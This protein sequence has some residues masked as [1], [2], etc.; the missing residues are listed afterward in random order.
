MPTMVKRIQTSCGSGPYN[1][2]MK[3]TCWNT[4]TCIAD[5]RIQKITPSTIPIAMFCRSVVKATPTSRGHGLARMATGVFSTLPMDMMTA[6]GATPVFTIWWNEEFAGLRKAHKPRG[7]PARRPVR[8]NRSNTSMQ[9]CRTIWQA[10]RGERR[11][12]QTVKCS[13]PFRP[14][15]R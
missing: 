3:S 8:W 10:S 2:C 14:H 4:R 5:S 11:V 7:L 15:S 1:C 12:T 6:L 9:S 13:F